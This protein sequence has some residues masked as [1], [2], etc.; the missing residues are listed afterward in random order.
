MN[1][2]VLGAT[3]YIGGPVAERLRQLGH[4]VSGLARTEAKAEALRARGI[5]P[6]VGTLD[7]EAR[8]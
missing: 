8:E 7:D 4:R 1:I 5:E 3:G 6:I 2:F